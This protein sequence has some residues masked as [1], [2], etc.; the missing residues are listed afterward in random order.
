MDLGEPGTIAM[1]KFE[2]LPVLNAELPRARMKGASR[3]I[4]VVWVVPLVAAIVAGYVAFDQIRDLGPKITIAFDDSS[5]VIAGETPVKYRGVKVGSVTRVTLSE[6]HKH[7][8]VNVR[9]QRS[10]ASIAKAGSVFWIARPELGVDNIASGLETVISGPEIR[11]APGSGKFK[12][13]FAGLDR[14][15]AAI[16]GGGLSIVLRASRIS[17]LRKKSPVTYRGVEVGM[18]QDIHLSP[19][20]TAADIQVLIDR[21][22]AGLVRDDSVFWNQS[23]VSVSGGLFSGVKIEMSSLQTLAVGGIAFATPRGN[24]RQAKS[25]AVFPLHAEPAEAWLAWAPPIPIPPVEG[26]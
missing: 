5:G 19:D 6:D 26:R 20:A 3:G 18:V 16:D 10:A 4:S 11:V 22:Y 23:G 12:S 14:A 7:A 2:E 9:L 17:S 24:G 8:K 15:P 25:G 1:S 21:R 13:D